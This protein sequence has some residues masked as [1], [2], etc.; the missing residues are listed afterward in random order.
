LT[1]A[2]RP[3]LV[4]QVHDALLDDL[5]E[6]TLEP[7]A[8]LPN[9]N[10]LADRFAVSRATIRE[11]VL[12]LL[13]AGY[14]SR[15]HG[16][17]TFVT[18]APRTRHALDTTVSYT[19]MIREAGHEPAENVISRTVRA[20]TEVERSLLDIADGQSLIEVERVRL[21]D[22]RPV[23]YSRDRIP[24][25]LLGAVA[26]TPLDSSLYD[27]L[28]GAGHPV[29]GARAQL[30]P[31]LADKELGRLLSIK[32]GTPLLHIDQVDYDDDGRAVMLSDEWHVADAFELIVN[33]R[34]TP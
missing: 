30:M 2:R 7:G 18:H 5:L 15:R 9:E 10:E 16:S 33:R 12:R 17:G 24:E 20:P 22:G 21:A 14:L 32:T 28:Y 13:E 23:I 25:S 26:Q 8:K 31:V 3:S 19:A 4:D 1:T 11:A 29:A 34:A 27:I 6:G